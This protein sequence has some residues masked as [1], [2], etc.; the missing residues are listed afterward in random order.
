MERARVGSERV[1]REGGREGENE[2]IGWGKEEREGMEWMR[3]EAEVMS[4]EREVR[5]TTGQV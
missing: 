1:K 4:S 5:V 3:R 2:E